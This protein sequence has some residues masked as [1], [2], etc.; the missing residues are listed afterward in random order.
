MRRG[1]TILG[2]GLAVALLAY[3]CLYFVST[4][5]KRETLRSEQPELAWLKREFNLSDAEFARVARQHEAYLPQCLE[6]CRRID[7][8]NAKLKQ[9]LAAASTMTPQ[10]EDA[11][12]EAARIRGECQRN[13]LRHFFDLSQTMPPEQGKRYLAWIKEKTIL[14][15]QGMGPMGHDAQP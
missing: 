2:L 1:F 13:M 9:L 7:E 5:S 14:P 4:S 8:Q 12:A 11:I 15:G 10:I 6:M 3:G